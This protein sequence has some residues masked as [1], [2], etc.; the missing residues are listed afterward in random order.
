MEKVRRCGTAAT[1]KARDGGV[2]LRGDHMEKRR[3]CGTAATT[4]ARGGGIWLRG[5]GMEKRSRCGEE[6]LARGPIQSARAR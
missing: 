3:R 5:G 1:T 4:K 2:W 6:E